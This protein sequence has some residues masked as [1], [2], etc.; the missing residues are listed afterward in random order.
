[1]LV[2][3][4]AIAG[5]ISGWASFPL[6]IKDVAGATGSKQ[7]NVVANTTTPAGY[8]GADPQRGYDEIFGYIP[9]FSTY[10]FKLDQVH[11]AFRDQMDYW[12]TFRRFYK[13]PMLVHEFVNWE[14]V[15]D[16]G[17]LRRLFA[18]E[19]SDVSDKFYVDCYINA[20]VTRAL[21]VVCRPSKHI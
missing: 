8:D 6:F 17:E 16:D 13:N 15:Q 12:Q 9:R 14:F 5:V 20:K 4:G 3:C 18:V 7:V 21:P 1:M 2:A 11:G 10:K 19:D